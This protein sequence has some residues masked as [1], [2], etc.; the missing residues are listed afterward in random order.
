MSWDIFVQDLPS[1]AKTAADIPSSFRPSL[2]GK[3]SEIID[4][5]IEII[6]AADFT[7]PSWGLIDGED[8]SIEVN[9]GQEEDCRGFAL[10]VRGGDVAVGAVAAILRRL[11]LR[12]LDSQSGEFFSADNNAIESFRQWRQYRDQVTES[13]PI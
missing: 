5:I 6:P 8:W 2:I 10:H 4:R 11:N 13:N 1:E 9:L 12:A 7:D 3:R